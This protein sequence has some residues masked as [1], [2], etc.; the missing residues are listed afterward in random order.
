MPCFRKSYLELV[1]PR[2]SRLASFLVKGDWWEME[3][4]S[5][6]QSQCTEWKSM[7]FHGKCQPGLT[8]WRLQPPESERRGGGGQ[9]IRGDEVE[10]KEEIRMKKMVRN[11]KEGRKY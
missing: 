1:D 5:V 11:R 3:A 2:V 4:V 10:R 7:R 9:E 8:F 6:S